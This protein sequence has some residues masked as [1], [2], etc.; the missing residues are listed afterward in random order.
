MAGFFSEGHTSF[1]QE[2]DAALARLGRAVGL[3]LTL[4]REG[5]TTV[6]IGGFQAPIT[7]EWVEPARCLA[8]HAPWPG[9]QGGGL[10]AEQLMALHTGGVGSFG[11]S[12]WRLPDG[13]LRIGALLYGPTL[14]EDHLLE[15][16][17]RVAK[18]AARVPTAR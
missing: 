16:A 7:F 10:P 3:P 18:M 15:A 4:G 11:T 5:A 1:R 2:V 8:V 12:F 14:S 6:R 17:G 13:Q 9:S